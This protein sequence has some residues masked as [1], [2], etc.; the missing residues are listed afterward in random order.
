M[1]NLRVL[2]LAIATTTV[3]ACTPSS[4]ETAR[5]VEHAAHAEASPSYG[6][7]AGRSIYALPGDWRDQ[8]AVGRPLY[9]LAGRPQIIAFAY[10]H[11]GYACPR[12][13]A[14]M[15]QIERHADEHRIDLGLTLVSID[16]ARD[17]PDRL[18]S[19]A[20]ATRL[21]TERWT[22]LNGSDDQI[23]ELAVLLGVRYHATENGEFAH[24]NTLIL[25]DREGV[26]VT[27][28]DGLDTELD[29][30]LKHLS[31]R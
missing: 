7:A 25:L 28:L 15:K 12:I 23:L 14:R 27:R 16:P 8:E 19:Y 9:S 11:C 2:V 17:T 21:G 30:L 29:P 5:S 13:V 1:S 24:T 18:A 10:T 4:P 26:P 22:L 31:L 6:S 3:P 20:N